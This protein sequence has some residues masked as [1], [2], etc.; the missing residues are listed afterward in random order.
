M[1][2]TKNFS[3]SEFSCKCG[4]EMPK[5]IENNVKKLAIQ[6]QIIRDIVNV[7]IK[8]NSGYRCEKHNSSIKGSSKN[9]QHLKGKAA[10]IVIK[11]YDPILKTFP[12]LDQL[13]EEGELIIGGIGKYSTFTHIDI[14]KN[15][16]RW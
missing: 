12:L 10:D 2:L 16:A 5:N 8:I 11:G 14:R 15:R 3:K 13:V 6:L 9:S 7:P 1:K 4:C